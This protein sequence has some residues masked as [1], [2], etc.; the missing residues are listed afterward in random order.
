MLFW[1]HWNVGIPLPNSVS[2]SRLL[3]APSIHT[4]SIPKVDV[5][6]G[7]C[8]TVIVNIS[9]VSWQSAVV[10]LCVYIQ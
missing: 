6:T 4:V 8:C 1:Y 5:N 9:L 7:P 2:T 3:T 10:G